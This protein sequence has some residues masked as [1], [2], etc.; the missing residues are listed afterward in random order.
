MDSEKLKVPSVAVMLASFNG[1][2]FIREQLDSIL[3]QTSVSVNI[4]IRDD[5]S[6]DSTPDILLEYARCFPGRVTLLEPFSQRFGAACEN[7]LSILMDVSHDKY[8]YFSFADQ[9]DVWVPDKLKRATTLLEITGASGYA[10][11]LKAFSED[12]NLEWIVKKDFAQRKF[13]HLFQAASAGCTY[14]LTPLALKLIQSRIGQLQV[15]TWTDMS[16]D[17]LCYAICRSYGLPWIIDNWTGIRYRQ[18]AA[19]QFG[20]LPGFQGMLKRYT[21][22]RSGWYRNVMI[23]N[24][25]FLDPA[26]Q[27]EL[28]IFRRL[29]EYRFVDRIWLAANAR[30]FRREKW[31]FIPLAFLLITGTI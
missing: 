31:R 8:D 7:F 1:E 18:H 10:S 16:H 21:L 3:L 24:G 2:D 9:D 30:K 19:N 11:N 4:Y 22:I 25:P 26:N 20:A 12:K 6:T 13:D 15:H 17:W 28:N 27:L 5:H 14:V 29:A 23:R